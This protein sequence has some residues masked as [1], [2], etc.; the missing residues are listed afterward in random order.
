MSKFVRHTSRKV[1]TTIKRIRRSMID[2]RKTSTVSVRPTLK[3]MRTAGSHSVF[4]VA[5]VYHHG[6]VRLDPGRVRLASDRCGDVY[7]C[8][9]CWGGR[10][11]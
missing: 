6:C 8:C 4:V 10:R 1:V 9:V 2:G 11:I 5:I 7:A 3:T